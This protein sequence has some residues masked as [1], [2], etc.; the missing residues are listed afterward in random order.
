VRPSMLLSAPPAR[1]AAAAADAASSSKPAGNGQHV[2]VEVE[3]EVR[4]RV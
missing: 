2:T 1:P 4:S 3:E